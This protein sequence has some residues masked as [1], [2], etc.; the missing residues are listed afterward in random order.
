MLEKE[1]E[2]D[3]RE[4]ASRQHRGNGLKSF[5]DALLRPLLGPKSEDSIDKK[6]SGLSEDRN[7]NSKSDAITNGSGDAF[8]ADENGSRGFGAGNIHPKLS[9]MRDQIADLALLADHLDGVEPTAAQRL[10]S[11]LSLFSRPSW[12][13]SSLIPVFVA[14]V[15]LFNSHRQMRIELLLQLFVTHTHKQTHLVLTP[16]SR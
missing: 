14:Q 3:I 4:A 8:A 9:E 6:G 2:Q 12:C 13:F 15:G 1:L 5:L 10:R 11:T 7:G 16:C